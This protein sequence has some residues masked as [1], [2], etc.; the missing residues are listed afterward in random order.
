MIDTPIPLKEHCSLIANVGVLKRLLKC[1]H[2][3]FFVNILAKCQC[4][5][6]T[7]SYTCG[8]GEPYYKHEMLVE[9]KD[10]RLARGHPIGQDVPYQ[11]MGGLTGFSSLM[12]GYLRLDPG[13]VLGYTYVTNDVTK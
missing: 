4:S 7:S 12:D 8:C 10:E 11:A 3:D 5:G 2:H 9:T 6:F 13:Q 1:F